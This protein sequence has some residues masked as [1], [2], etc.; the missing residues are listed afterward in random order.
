MMQYTT[1]AAT[2]YAIGGAA[3]TTKGNI[4][5]LHIVPGAGAG[6]FKLEAGVNGGGQNLYPSN[7]TTITT[8]AGGSSYT[9]YF[10]EPINTGV[11]CYVTIVDCQ[12]TV[13]HG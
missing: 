2:G 9:I 8:V 13:E 7:A 12:V 10:K 5:S 6:S 4:H 1:L 3:D 11:Q